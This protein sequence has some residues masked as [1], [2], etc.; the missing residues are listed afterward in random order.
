MQTVGNVGQSIPR[1]YAIVD[2]R[3][4]EHH[5]SIIEMDD[6]ICDQAISILI[7]RRSNYKYVSPY[8]V[9]KC[10]SSKELHAKSW[11]VQLAT[12]TKK[13]VH[14]WVRY[15]VFDLNGMPTTTHLNVL[16]LGSYNMLL[17][18]D[19]LY[20]HRTK[21]DCYDKSIEC[22]DDNRGPRVL[23][24]KKKATSVRM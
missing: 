5:V 23:Q 19:W 9:D 7:D 13:R 18:M 6:K 2:S 1:I 22:V 15:C 20:L 24:G 8:L 17:G 16:L 12:G 14:H 11:L 4:E 3:Q 21:V 10:G